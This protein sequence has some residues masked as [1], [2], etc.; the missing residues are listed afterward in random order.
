MICQRVLRLLKD[1][2]PQVLLVLSLVSML[3]A[4]SSVLYTGTLGP[5]LSSER[6]TIPV[7]ST[8]DVMTTAGT[9]RSTTTY[10]ATTVSSYGSYG[11]PSCPYGGTYFSSIYTSLCGWQY[12]VCVTFDYNCS[13]D[14]QAVHQALLVTKTAFATT[15]NTAYQIST[16]TSTFIH[17]QLGT[18][19]ITVPNKIKQD[20]VTFSV[21]LA[22]AGF[23]ILA[24]SL[25]LSKRMTSPRPE[26]MVSNS[27]I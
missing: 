18:T 17:S 24:A 5:V 12:D 9:L 25:L 8:I 6:V 27:P 2:K 22:V 11:S 3:A 19:V 10:K 7:S 14:Y 21:F 20:F 4:F 23:A 26:L 15:T 13:N 1:R 16:S